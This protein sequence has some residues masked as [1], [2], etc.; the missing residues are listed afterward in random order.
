[1]SQAAEQI[2]RQFANANVNKKTWGTIF[3]NVKAYGA[4]GNGVTNDTASIQAAIEDMPDTGGTLLFPEG[5][6]LIDDISIPPYPKV[7]N[8][9]GSGMRATVLQPYSMNTRILKTV[10]LVGGTGVRALGNRIG[11]FSIKAH[12]SGSTAE[13]IDVKGFSNALFQ[14]IAYLSNGSGN[15]T[16]MFD[17][18]SPT[19]AGV[20][21]STYE[22]TF[23]G[24]FCQ[25]QTIT[26]KLFYF[27]NKGQGTGSNSNSCTIRNMWVYANSSLSCAIDAHNSTHTKISDCQFESNPLMVSIIAG[28]ACKIRDNW[29]ELNATEI[30]YQTIS[31]NGMVVGNYFSGTTI[32][33]PVGVEGNVWMMNTGGTHPTFTGDTAKNK[34]FRNSDFWDIPAFGT[35]VTMTKLTASPGTFSV[36]Q[37]NMVNTNPDEISYELVYI[38]TPTGS[39]NCQFRI[40]I[41]TG[42]KIVRLSLGSYDGGSGTP[43]PI[44]I[45]A[46]ENEFWGSFPTAAIGYTITAHVTFAR[47]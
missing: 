43:Y 30:E 8:I 34:V 42:F 45:T 23:D 1:M 21:Y 27:N 31:N 6:Y 37:T 9:Q 12:A 40:N 24:I 16:Y 20:F 46:T 13:A 19:I 29:F 18:S 32:N 28:N 22:N 41:P 25:E 7:V 15:Y 11:D 2:A 5:T 3:Y 35:P 4:E 26:G 17:I 39:G 14:N 33:F 38:W 36:A 10:P 44:A 47:V